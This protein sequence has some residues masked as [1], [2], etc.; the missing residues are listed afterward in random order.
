MS[1]REILDILAAIA[2]IL[3]GVAA[4]GGFFV[5]WQKR[6]FHNLHEVLKHHVEKIRKEA[7]DK[8]K[9]S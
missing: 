4:V 3:A 8:E 1:L 5:A 6:F 9:N 2:T 7:K